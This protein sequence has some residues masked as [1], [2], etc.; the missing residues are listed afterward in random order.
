MAT[1][2]IPDEVFEALRED[3]TERLRTNDPTPLLVQLASSHL[4]DVSAPGFDCDGLTGLLTRQRLVER[5]GRA[6]FGAS[7]TDAT[8]YRERFLCIDLDK[9]KH[10][11]DVYSLPAGDDVLRGLATELRDHYGPDDVYRFGGDE[12]AVVLGDR[13]I[14][15][16]KS[17]AAVTLTHAVVVV[18]LHR[19]QHRNYHLI[20]WIT[21]HLVGGTLGATPEGSRV[22]C[23]DP[24]WLRPG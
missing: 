2:E 1:V 16:P 19:S 12:F 5:L 21:L 13:D 4:R 20:E 8:V 14:W 18:D 3:S 22:E 15:L 23:G 7:W 17:P 6:T 10:Y 11:L 24:P 9:F